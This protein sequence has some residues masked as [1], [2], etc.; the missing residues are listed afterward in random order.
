MRE[1]TVLLTGAT[2]F[3]GKNVFNL[4]VEQY[5]IRVVIRPTNKSTFE[6]YSNVEVV[7]SNDI[8]LESEDWW[9]E[10]CK[11]VD[12][13][14]H[15]A[16]YAEPGHYLE[17][18]LNLKCLIGTLNLANAARKNNVK[19]FVGIGTCFEY[20]LNN[21]ILSV[22]SPLNPTTL[23]ASAKVSVFLTLKELFKKSET[24]FSWCRLFYLYGKGEDSRRLVPYIRNKI[25]KGE[26][27]DLTSGLQVRDY[28][29]VEKAAEMITD[30]LVSNS[31]GPINVCS[32]VGI[33]V[34]ELAE[35]IASEYGRLD[36][37]NFGA[38]AEN[39]IDPPCVIGVKSIL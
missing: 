1:W 13:I 19:K 7:Y 36:L 3:V 34:K 2:G 12:F 6:S 20:D 37:L 9:I 28:L 33:T 29:N 22:E 31:S 21:N 5:N 25:S 38:R 32:G 8:F 24:M 23:Y 15:C 35:K 11:S 14:I 39:L 26:K 17:S 18:E 4:L 30:I 27:A 10:V 16:W